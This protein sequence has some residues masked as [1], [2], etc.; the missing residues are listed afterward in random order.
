MFTDKQEYYISNDDDSNNI[1]S[2]NDFIYEDED[3]VIN[4]NDDVFENLN[5]DDIFFRNLYNF[6]VYINNYKWSKISFYCSSIFI[7]SILFYMFLSII[8]K[9]TIG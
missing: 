5:K 9:T 6:V 2:N 3:N 1:D 8:H 7:S 4:Y